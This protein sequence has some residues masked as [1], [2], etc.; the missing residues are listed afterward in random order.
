LHFVPRAV[1]AALGAVVLAIAFAVPASAAQTV[2]VWNTPSAFINPVDLRAVDLDDGKLATRVVLPDGYA[3]RKCW[4]VIYLLHGTGTDTTPAP[5]EWIDQM[6]V[7][8]TGA[9]A[10]LVIP[11]GGPMWWSDQWWNGLRRPGWESWVL[12]EL[13][14]LVEKRIHVCGDRSQ[15][16]IAGYSMGGYGAA[17]LG[18]Q[19]PDYF[20]SVAS[21]SGVLT[22]MTP[23][24]ARLQ[25]NFTTIWGP[26]DGAYAAGHDP[27]QVVGNLRSTRVL[28]SAGNGNPV[29]AETI[30]AISRYEET[31]F[32]AQSAAYV[33]VARKNGVAAKLLNH[34]G[35]HTWITWQQDFQRLLAWNPFKRVPAQPR[36]WQFTTVATRGTA[37]QYRFAFKKPP[38]GLVRFAQDGATLTAQGKGTVTLTAAGGLRVTA[39]LPFR[40]KGGEATPLKG[41]SVVKPTVPVAAAPIK[42]AVTPAAP[43]AGDPITVS[44]TT[45]QALPADQEYAV[46][47]LSLGGESCA[48]VVVARI[49]QP[50]K[51]QPVTAT[52][53]PDGDPA[54]PRTTWCP[55]AAAVG[56]VAVKKGGEVSVAGDILGYATLSLPS[57]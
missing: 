44:F 17:Y 16:A 48:Q 21:F 6:H 52:L 57:S 10:I 28:V 46:A 29:G 11:G 24:F 47:F 23:A 35:G 31:T 20:G 49:S 42:V 4:P 39:K 51:G 27:L 9:K 15:H 12:Q 45:T 3:R 8:Q 22:P 13:I 14:P 19:R 53:R 50:A 55:G 38:S 30:T 5:R 36:K 37:W 56:V 1:L 33:K 7:D 26:I 41:Q 40:L 54:H 18:A 2:Q 32:A 34:P 43:Q 25:S